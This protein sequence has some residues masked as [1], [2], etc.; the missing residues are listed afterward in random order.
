MDSAAPR[1]GAGP[2]RGMRYRTNSAASVYNP[3]LLGSYEFELHPVAE[4]IC[5]LSPQ[6]IVD[7]GAAE[8]YYAVGFAL[9][10]PKSRVI[11]FEMDK[12]ALAGLRRLA[13][14]N[15]CAERVELRGKCTPAELRAC[16]IDA[17][18]T[19][20]ICDVEGFESVLL[21]PL[22]VPRLRNVSILV[23]LH[24]QSSPGVTRLLLDR[25]SHTHGCQVIEYQKRQ[26]QHIDPFSRRCSRL[27]DRWKMYLLSERPV[28][29]PWL[30]MRALP[31]S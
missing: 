2:F 31:E 21:D 19:V 14:M 3:K 16:L 24:E 10:L 29:T 1:V 5:A 22:D 6:C 30:W 23:E 4:A 12:S 28:A 20:L 18:R 9:R 17:E 27:P 8:G 25:F 11:A 26:P 7:V 15:R 13:A